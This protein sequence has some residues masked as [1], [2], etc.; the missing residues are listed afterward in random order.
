MIKI[1]K[2]ANKKEKIQI[3]NIRNG[4]G[5]LSM[6]LNLLGVNRRRNMVVR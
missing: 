5:D 1:S 2:K 3:D 6:E 4:K